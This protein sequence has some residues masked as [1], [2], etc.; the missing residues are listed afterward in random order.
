MKIK[1]STKLKRRTQRY[2]FNK[3]VN[4]MIHSTLAKEIQVAIDDQIIDMLKD[5]AAKEQN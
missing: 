5:I 2:M 3:R 1:I 4:K